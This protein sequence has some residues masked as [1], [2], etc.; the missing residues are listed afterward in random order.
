MLQGES[1]TL[2]MKLIVKEDLKSSSFAEYQF[3]LVMGTTA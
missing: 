1:K 3:K 2:V